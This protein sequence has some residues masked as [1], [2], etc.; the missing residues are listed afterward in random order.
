MLIRNKGR[1]LTG[2]LFG[3]SFLVLLALI[4]TPAFGGRNGLEFAEQLFNRLAKGSSYFVPQLSAELR[5][6]EKQQVAVSVEMESAEQAAR[7]KVIFSRVAPDTAAQGAM[8]KVRGDLEPILASALEDCR[9]MY[10]NHGDELREKYGMDEKEA[11]VVWHRSLN[12]IAKKLQ[13]GD[14]RNVAQSKMILAVVTK[15]VEPAY[16]FYG[17]EPERVSGRSGI[18]TLLLVF[19]LVYTVW[20]GFAIYFMFEGLGLAMTKARIKREV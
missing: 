20:W 2:L 3:A 8:L 18:T 5:G 13:A 6:F 16:N 1:A 10:L 4:F 15:G 7:A 9:A 19:Y 11:M 14:R 17:I 12:G